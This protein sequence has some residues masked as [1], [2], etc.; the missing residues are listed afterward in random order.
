[1]ILFI[2]GLQMPIWAKKESVTLKIRMEI[3]SL[4]SIKKKRLKKS[5]QNLKDLH[6]VLGITEGE[7]RERGRLNMWRNFPNLMNDMNINI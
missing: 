4:R 1:M 3:M 5:E 7:E 2:R 6:T